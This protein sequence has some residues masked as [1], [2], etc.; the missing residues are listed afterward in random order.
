MPLV[1][2]KIF[3]KILAVAQS[4]SRVTP[5]DFSFRIVGIKIDVG[6]DSAVGIPASDLSLDVTQHKLFSARA[7]LFDDEPRVRFSGLVKAAK[8]RPA[9]TCPPANSGFLGGGADASRFVHFAC[10]IC[11]PD[12]SPAV[13]LA[14][15]GAPHS[16]QYCEP[17][18]FS[19]LHLSQ[20]IIVV[21]SSKLIH[22]QP[23]N[24]DSQHSG[25]SF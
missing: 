24:A 13:R 5:R 4:D 16:S 19:V 23:R 1:E 2:P 18:R 21:Y 17:S 12:R 8:L 3:K 25:K 6:E 10:R 14:S 20:V 9:E 7:T 22:I 11:L 15:S